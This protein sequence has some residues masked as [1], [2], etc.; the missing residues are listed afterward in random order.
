MRAVDVIR[1][2]RD[3][4]TLDRE[5]IDFF[6]SGVTSG[7]LPDYQ[8]SALLLAIL[9]RGIAAPE[10]AARRD[11]MGRSGIRVD[12]PGLD[13]A[14]VDRHSTGRVGD[15]TPLILAPRA[16]ACGAYVPMM[17]GRGLGHTG[18]TV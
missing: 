7:D 16:A 10:P 3:G 18:G 9:I 12:Y 11:A 5:E 14:P 15:K 2:K 4:R 1:H 8:A 6:V 17:S 13:G